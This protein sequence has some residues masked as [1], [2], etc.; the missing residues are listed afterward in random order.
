VALRGI[1]AG[2]RLIDCEAQ[3]EVDQNVMWWKPPRGCSARVTGPRVIVLHHTAGERDPRGVHNTLVSRKSVAAPWGLSV[4][5][6]IGAD[7]T[8]WQMA[9]ARSTKTLHAG[10]ANAW[11]VGVEIV[12]RGA[13]PA[14]ATAPRETYSDRIHG[15]PFDYLR[16][17]PAQ[18]GAAYTLCRALCEVLEIPYRF[19]TESGAVTRGI[20]G[21][22][23]IKTYRGI[24]GHY[25]VSRGKVDPS[26][27]LL[28]ELHAKASLPRD[29]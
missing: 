28:D 25:H 1:V 29:P 12:N 8:I 18:V 6:V 13:P 14:L 10:R 24:L 21:E 2:G 7:G 17:H 3:I 4:H 23:E 15:I 16:F 26:P 9:D 19:P 11:S 5:F 27:H 22:S 20:M